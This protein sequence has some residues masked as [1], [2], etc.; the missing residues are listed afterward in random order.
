MVFTSENIIDNIEKIGPWSLYGLAEE[1]IHHYKPWIKYV[2]DPNKKITYQINAM[3]KMGCN[4]WGEMVIKYQ[5]E[6]GYGDAREFN[7][8]YINEY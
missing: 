5:K 3:V 6:V 4:T 2:Q 7:P 8:D 1:A